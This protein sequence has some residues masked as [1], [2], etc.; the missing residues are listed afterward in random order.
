MMRSNVSTISMAPSMKVDTYRGGSSGY[1]GGNSMVNIS[2]PFI[3]DMTRTTSL[4]NVNF[5][6]KIY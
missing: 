3:E 1:I 4:S 5:A 2:M 6:N